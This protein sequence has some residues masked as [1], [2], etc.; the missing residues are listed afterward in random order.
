[1]PLKT[2]FVERLQHSHFV[3]SL[4]EL[5]D[6]AGVASSIRPEL[7]QPEGPIAG[8]NGGSWASRVVVPVA[9][10]YE[11]GPACSAIGDVGR[12]GEVLVTDPEPESGR[13]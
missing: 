9:A 1:M 6:D 12:A 7:L 2:R 5:L 3:A 11:D 13:V 8:R 4:F 10:V